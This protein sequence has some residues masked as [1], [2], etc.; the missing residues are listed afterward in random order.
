MTVLLPEALAIPGSVVPAN[1]LA[2]R[3]SRAAAGLLAA[4]M[5]TVIPIS[6]AIGRDDAIDALLDEL[7]P[8]GSIKSAMTDAAR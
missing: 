2:K 3:T 6:G 5:F 7:G 4:L 1:A 8:A